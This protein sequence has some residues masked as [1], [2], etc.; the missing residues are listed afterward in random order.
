MA[1]LYRL[2]VDEGD[3]WYWEGDI[4]DLL[5]ELKPRQGSGRENSNVL[6]LRRESHAVFVRLKSGDLLNLNQVQKI[7]PCP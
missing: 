2:W 5:D 6:I 3:C 1:N 7:E 4:E